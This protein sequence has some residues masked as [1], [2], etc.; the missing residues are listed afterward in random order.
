M[1]KDNFFLALDLG[2]TTLVGRL[3]D[4]AG[5][6]RAE[7]R[8]LNPQGA[9]A[10][11]IIR[12][13]EA[14]RAGR[15]AELQGLL[16]QGIDCLTAELLRLAGVARGRL[17]SA[18]LAANPGIAHLLA[19]EP[20]ESLLF[21]PHRPA[22]RGG[23][24]F[25]PA[26]FRL[27]LPCA[28]YLFPLVSGYVGGDLVAFLYGQ[29]DPAAATLYVDIGTNAELALH[30]DDRRLVSSVAA[31]PAFEGGEITCGMMRTTGAVEDVRVDGD[32][33]RLAVVGQG[34]PRGL[35]G[36]GLVTA[37]AAALEGGLMDRAGTLRAPGDVTT[38]LARYLMEKAGQ[39]ALRLYRDA[40]VD[41]LITQED[42]RA[43][44]LAKGAVHA[45]VTCLL[46]RAGVTAEA[47]REVVVTG[48]FGAALGRENLKRVALLPDSVIEK[49]RFEADGA[50]RG[51]ARFLATAGAEDQVARL[52]AS[53]RPYPLSGTPAFEKAFIAALNF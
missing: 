43:F 41:L 42:V 2:T 46:E 8:C 32:R 26:R 49:V 20:V 33:L 53:L 44:Q 5:V 51:V 16:A 37:V 7:G 17:A 25:P 36:S 28:V 48:A 39:R 50:L 30:A 9:V 6:V 11:D 31:G 4:D 45:G 1:T 13:L 24:F 47:L 40:A 52:A 15:G 38:N 23:A 18:A 27:D 10:P 29:G 22:F 34:A 12:R 19:A 21:P 3:L 35:C 14:A